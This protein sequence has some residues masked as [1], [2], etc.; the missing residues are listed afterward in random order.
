MRNSLIHFWPV[1]LAVILG[2]AVTCAVV[3]GALL[4]GDSVRGSLTS[5]TLQRLGQIDYALV[6]Q[7]FFQED[8]AQKL[9]SELSF[10]SYVGKVAPAILLKGTAVFPNTGTRASKVG[11]QGI[12]PRFLQVFNSK[13]NFEFAST[14][15]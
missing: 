6:T 11:I 9:E 8:L 14:I 15:T 1:H 7:R 13:L 2:V 3:T 5:L 4:V 12:D 10:T